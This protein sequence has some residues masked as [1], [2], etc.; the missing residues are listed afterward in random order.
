MN[1]GRRGAAAAITAGL[2]VAMSLGLLD[3]SIGILPDAAGA[4][5]PPAVLAALAVDIV[6]VLAIFVASLVLA[7]ILPASATVR[8]AV[9]CS[10]CVIAALVVEVTSPL[11]TFV[12]TACGPSVPL[13]A[14]SLFK[15]IFIM[16]ALAPL[17]AL[18]IVKLTAALDT[19][20]GPVL[21]LTQATPPLIL[22]AAALEWLYVG[23]RVPY[24]FGR[25]SAF[26][27]AAVLL[28]SGTLWLLWRSRGIRRA[29]TMIVGGGA[30]LVVGAAPWTTAVPTGFP[31]VDTA[32]PVARRPLALPHILLISIDALRAD[33]ALPATGQTRMPNVARLARQA[34]TFDHAVAPSSWTVPSIGSWLTGVSPATHRLGLSVRLSPRFTTLAEHLQDAGYRTAAILGNP[35]LDAPNNVSRGFTDFA[36]VQRRVPPMTRFQSAGARLL[37]WFKP[38]ERLPSL[39]TMLTERAVSWLTAHAA[40]PTFLWVHYLD[41]HAPYAAPPE[42]V[43]PPRRTFESEKGPWAA[44]SDWPNNPFLTKEMY[45]AAASFVDANVGRLFETLAAMKLY[46]ETLIIVT[47]DHGEEMGDHNHWGHAFTLYGETIRV[48][49]IIKLPRASEPVVVSRVVSTQDLYPTILDLSGVKYD[50]EHLESSSLAPSIRGEGGVVAPAP[51]A[52]W[53]I[54]KGDDQVAVMWNGLKYILSE[55]TG[56]EEL[57]D[58]AADPGELDSLAA[59]RPADIDRARAILASLKAR[60]QQLRAYYGTTRVE[61]AT[62]DDELLQRLR[63]LGYVQ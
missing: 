63:S 48:P 12:S 47:A 21:V 15:L 7:R 25:G 35:L 57:Y 30:V 13:C 58:L 29:A 38:P 55:I 6:A 56:R 8:L 53:L 28:M 24:S 18:A 5:Q 62:P 26:A 46:D 59:A 36:V 22:E 27:A 14:P 17:A 60:V 51:V 40:E 19:T 9:A 61:K 49:L 20:S 32:P 1:T 45:T 52:A 54:G 16:L 37:E 2:G 41:P 31:R 34:A 50:R 23:G 3:V 39:T 4:V 10:V 33:V 11:L 42:Y 44:E 43:H